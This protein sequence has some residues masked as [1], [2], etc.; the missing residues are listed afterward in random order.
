[1]NNLIQDTKAKIMACCTVLC[2]STVATAFKIGLRGIS[3]MLFVCYVIFFSLLFFILYLSFTQKWKLFKTATKKELYVAAISGLLNPFAYYAVLFAAY[4]K[5]PAQVAQSLNYVW[6]IVL[7]VA[8]AFLQKRKI[9]RN[10]YV[11]LFTGFAGV[12]FIASKGNF[13]SFSFDLLGVGCALFSSII[14]V[15]YWLISKASKLNPV[16]FL[17][18]NQL[19]GFIVT[20]LF[21]YTFNYK[22]IIP[23]STTMLAAMYS[24]WFEMGFTFVLWITALR[25][26]SSPEKISHYIFLSPFISLFFIRFLLDEQIF[27]S[28]FIGLFL[29]V[30]GIILSERG[31]NLLKFFKMRE[32]K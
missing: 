32:N 26:A 19:I 20:V 1:M 30:T 14:W 24:G 27:F 12:V 6:P 4:H 10:I 8:S 31:E 18:T 9:P 2:W 17:F 3:P 29:I 25:L 23:D 22:F 21:L 5:L 15:T 16:I 7:V 13:F 28:T 11:G